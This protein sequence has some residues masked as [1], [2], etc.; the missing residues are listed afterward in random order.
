MLSH[1]VIIPCSHNMLSSHAI[2]PFNHVILFSMYHL[3]SSG[4]HHSMLSSHLSSHV[5]IPCYNS[6]LSSHTVVPCYHLVIS[7]YVITLVENSCLFLLF[8]K[9]LVEQRWGSMR[10]RIFKNLC[11]LQIRCYIFDC[12]CITLCNVYTHEN[13]SDN[14]K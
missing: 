13:L 7:S 1:N 11:L 6:M 12:S 10:H 3:M 4:H 5:I 8:L 14:K 2:N 9:T